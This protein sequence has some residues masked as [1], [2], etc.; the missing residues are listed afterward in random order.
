MHVHTSSDEGE[1]VHHKHAPTH[2]HVVLDILGELAEQLA[3]Q[4]R[5][6]WAAQVQPLVGIVVP[7]VVLPPPQR[8]QQQPVDHVPQEECL[9]VANDDP[10]FGIVAKKM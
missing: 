6:Q 3:E 10:Y 4:L 8:H 1:G 9:W 5:E 7:V 2:L